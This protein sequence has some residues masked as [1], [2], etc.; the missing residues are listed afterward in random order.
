[1]P[2]MALVSSPC[3]RLCAI[4]ATSGLCRGCGRTLGEIAAWG[5]LSEAE[6]RRTMAA[7]PAR[8]A[9]RDRG[10]AAAPSPAALDAGRPAP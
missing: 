2:G 8:L 4:D 7:L 9:A 5:G 1:M 10:S 6:R 3:I